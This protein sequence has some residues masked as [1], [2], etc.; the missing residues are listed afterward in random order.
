M[1][2]N[3]LL[4]Y[5]AQDATGREYHVTHSEACYEP[6]FRALVAKWLA[7]LET[8]R[9]QNAYR[10]THGGAPVLPVRIVITPI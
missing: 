7:F 5:A 10:S 3:P 6:D 1:R 8:P 4:R 2:V 9:A